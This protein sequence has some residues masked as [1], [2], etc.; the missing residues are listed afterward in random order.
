MRLSLEPLARINYL[1]REVTCK[2]ASSQLKSNI[3]H[4]VDEERFAKLRGKYQ[5]DLKR[6]AGNLGDRYRQEQQGDVLTVRLVSILG[7]WKM[8]HQN[9]GK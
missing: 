5:R 8:K 3:I 9:L 7:K 2:L 1:F 4:F 6:C